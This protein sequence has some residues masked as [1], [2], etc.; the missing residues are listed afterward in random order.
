MNAAAAIR[1]SQ[2]ADV[3]AIAAIYRHHVLHGVASFEELPPDPAE[4]AR[5]RT[6][7]TARGLPYLVAEES[8][9]VVGFC[10]AS[11]YRARSAYRFTVEDSIYVDEASL[12]RGVGRA[13]LGALVERCTALGYRQMI[14]VIGGSDQWPSIGLH[15]A[16]GFS[17]VGLL[18]AVGA[19]FGG[20]IDIV[21]MQRALGSGAASA[22]EGNGG[23]DG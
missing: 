7:I 12:G 17:G 5:R 8:G 18:P 3:A 4:I 22:P 10:Y 11:R 9:R 19:K 14:A 13:L 1:P 15:R 21:L 20:W 23:N 16:L 2:D 6:E